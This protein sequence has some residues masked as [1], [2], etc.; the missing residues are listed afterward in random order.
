MKSKFSSLGLLLLLICLLACNKGITFAP[1]VTVTTLT[2]KKIVLNDLRGKPV[3]VTFWAT[4]CPS[5]IEETS[6][7]IDLYTRYH[8]SG[9]EIIAVAMSYDPPNH[10]IEM[11]N[12]LQLPYNVALDLNSELADA[13]GGIMVTPSTYLIAPDGGIATKIFGVFDLKK[14]HTLIQSLLRG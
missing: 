2:G 12:D 5:C 10:V 3:I 1:E 8:E 13:F 7:L 4:D 6:N 11:S 9:F 14:M